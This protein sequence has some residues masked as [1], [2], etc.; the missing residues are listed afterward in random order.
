VSGIFASGWR[1]SQY[2]AAAETDAA[3]FSCLV[4]FGAMCAVSVGTANYGTLCGSAYF[5]QT[6]GRKHS[7]KLTDCC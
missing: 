1:H 4:G 6:T 5:A 2:V 3:R 7:L